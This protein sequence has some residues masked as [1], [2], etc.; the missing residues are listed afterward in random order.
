L[1]SP[2]PHA[3][4]HRQIPRP[5]QEQDQ[6]AV[7]ITGKPLEVLTEVVDHVTFGLGGRWSGRGETSVAAV[8]RVG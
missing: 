6:T 2:F 5:R 8:D 7:L 1:N 4:R 3:G